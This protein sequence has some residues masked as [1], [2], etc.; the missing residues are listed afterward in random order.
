MARSG[1]TIVNPAT[2]ETVTFVQTAAD[3][4]GE[5]L[6]LDDVWSRPG[7]RAAPHVHPKLE[8]RF[9]V[10]TGRAALLVDGVEHT[11]EPGDALAVPPGTPHVAWNAAE[12]ETRLRLEFRPAGRWE[13]V[14]ARLFALA[15]EGRTDTYGVPEPKVLAAILT[16]FGEEI[17]P[18]L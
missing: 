13:E 3:T 5:V 1:E 4:D 10:V 8:E 17:A 12:G 2:G 15:Q 6:V 11:L 14:V 16:E 18:A 9:E 7:H